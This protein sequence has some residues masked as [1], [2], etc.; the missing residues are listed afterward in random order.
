MLPTACFAFEAMCKDA[1]A[2]AQSQ[3]EAQRARQRQ[4]AREVLLIV[5]EA[6]AQASIPDFVAYFLE[7]FRAAD[8]STTLA[9]PMAL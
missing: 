4:R 1:S 5:N 9:I 7:C 8:L 6:D 3:E 2:A